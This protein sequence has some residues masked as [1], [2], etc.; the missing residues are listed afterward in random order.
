MRWLVDPPGPDLHIKKN[1]FLSVLASL[2]E[3]VGQVA[4]QAL[5]DIH[6]SDQ[7][8]FQGCESA[9]REGEKKIRGKKGALNL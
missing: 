5:P 9:Y 4:P 8:L 1:H 3:S 7:H 6:L 2:R